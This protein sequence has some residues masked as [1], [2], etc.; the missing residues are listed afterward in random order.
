MKLTKSQ[1]KEMIR[2]EMR[3]LNETAPMGK[4]NKV[5]FMKYFDLALKTFL[6]RFHQNLYLI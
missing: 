3:S 5:K 6:M 1:L 2:E 4:I